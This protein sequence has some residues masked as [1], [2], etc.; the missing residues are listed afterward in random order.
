MVSASRD[1]EYI[2]RVAHLMGFATVRGS[3][4]KRG[5]RAI[6]QLVDL[7]KKGQNAGIV[8]DGSQ[9]PA[10]KVQAGV[11]LLAGRSGAPIL[12]FA[13]SSSRYLT[14]SSWDRTVLPL[15]FSRIDVCYGEPLFVPKKLASNDLQKYRMI[16]EERMNSLYE[17]AWSLHGK[18]HHEKR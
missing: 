8:A 18:K 7:L 12:P 11:I 9:G 6:I 3:R 16:L 17:Y 2:A 10:R 14:F 13:W 15:P 1:G 5:L 4:T